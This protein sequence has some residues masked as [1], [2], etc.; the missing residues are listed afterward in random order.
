[1]FLNSTLFPGNVVFSLK[2]NAFHEDDFSRRVMDLFKVRRF[3]IAI[4]FSLP[5]FVIRFLQM[6]FLKI[7]TIEYFAQLA[8][9]L[10]EERKKNKGMLFIRQF[11]ISQFFEIQFDNL[12]FILQMY[13]TMIS[14]A[15]YWKPKVNRW[16]RTMMKLAISSKNSPKRRS[17][18][19]A[20]SSSL[21]EW[22]RSA[23]HWRCFCTNWRSTMTSRT[24][25]TRNSWRAIRTPTWT[26]MISTSRSA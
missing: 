3:V 15:C 9:R 14:L 18:A 24:S 12:I 21:R 23:R 5:K 6:S 16:R 7:E 11:P 2:T 8:L 13:N 4:L 26:M 10:I 25:C 1:M 22:R 17:W 20:L 19:N